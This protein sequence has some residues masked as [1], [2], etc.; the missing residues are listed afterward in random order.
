MKALEKE[1]KINGYTSRSLAKKLGVSSPSVQ[2]WVKG[3]FNPSPG[4]IVKLKALGFSDLACLTPAA[5][6]EI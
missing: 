1:M 5:E 2:G 4:K 3:D 6:V